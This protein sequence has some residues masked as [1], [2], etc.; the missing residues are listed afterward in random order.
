MAT[1]TVKQLDAW[2]RAA[3]V[4]VRRFAVA[5]NLFLEVRRKAVDA[6]PSASWVFRWRFEGKDHSC[7]LGRYVPSGLKGQGVTLLQ[8]SQEASALRGKIKAG[9]GD[10]G[11]ERRA[12]RDHARADAEEARLRNV[13]IEA[14]AERAAAK[15]VQTVRAACDAWHSAT[16]GKL[17]S[18]KYAAQRARRLQDYYSYIGDV[19]A[20]DLKTEHVSSAFDA[21]LSEIAG[22]GL[23]H[24]GAETLR[25]SSADLEKAWAYAAGKGWCT[26]ANPVTT[27]R[28]NLDKPK[29]VGRRFFEVEKL[30]DFWG[31]AQFAGQDDRYPVALQLLR[32]LTLT[33][34][35]TLELRRLQWSE[36]EGLDGEAPL[37]RVPADRMK[38][39]AAWVVP[40]SPASANVLRTVKR[41]QSEA[42]ASLKGVKAGFV[43]VHLAGNYKGRVLS[44]NAVN[45]LLQGMGWGESLT[46]HGLRKVF[47][48][49]AHDQWPYHGPN[50]TEAIEYSL[51][52]APADKVR[53]TYDKNDFTG[54]RRELLTWWAGHLE[55][56]TAEAKKAAAAVVDVTVDEGFESAVQPMKLRRVK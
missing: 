51:A 56:V 40:L 7:G 35:R 47:S 13:A 5:Q 29:A 31:A 11:T 41:W 2:V 39:R 28:A 17:T 54:K 4:G 46:A 1:I 14:A 20:A 24:S 19:P 52:H 30:A 8:A 25:R 49:I 48:T 26:G 18:P 45:D 32:L 36:V 33:G 43:F 3:P 53:G 6:S 55:K 15:A 37:V 50:R 34:A 27:A 23:G 44:E 16:A 21:M 42:G 38:R 9:N 22:A 12:A 10:L